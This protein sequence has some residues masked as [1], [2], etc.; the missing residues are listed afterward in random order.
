MDLYLRLTPRWTC[1]LSDQ[2]RMISIAE[3]NQCL[4]I[5]KVDMTVVTSEIYPNRLQIDQQTYP[6]EDCRL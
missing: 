5:L 3:W 2:E 1:Y 6:N 4:M